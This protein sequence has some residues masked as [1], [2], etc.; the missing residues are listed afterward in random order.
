MVRI[1]SPPPVTDLV[2]GMLEVVQV[3]EHQRHAGA[4][5]LRTPEH[6]VQR[7]EQAAAIEQL[8]QRVDQ[9]QPRALLG[10]AIER[11]VLVQPDT[12][13]A[14]VRPVADRVHA[15][16]HQAAVGQ[17]D[18]AIGQCDLAIA[19][20]RRHHQPVD[21]RRVAHAHL[22]AQGRQDLRHVGPGGHRPERPDLAEHGIGIQHALLRIDEQDA[23]A[24]RT[25]QRRQPRALVVRA[26]QV[27]LL[28]TLAL[29]QRHHAMADG[30]RHAVETRR[31]AAD[32]VAGLHRN[33]DVVTSRRDL[34]A[35]G[36][37]D[38]QVARE[39]I[40]DRR[41]QPDRRG[42]GH[43]GDE[44]AGGAKLV[45]CMAQVQGGQAQFDPCELLAREGHRHHPVRGRIRT[46]Q[47]DRTGVA[48]RQGLVLVPAGTGHRVP[49][50]VEHDQ[51]GHD[52]RIANLVEHLL[53]RHEITFDDGLHQRLVEQPHQF[54]RLHGRLLLQRALH[55]P[56]AAE[57]H[58]HH[59]EQLHQHTRHD[60]LAAQ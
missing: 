40:G 28:L 32:L 47:V 7:L 20:R 11:D 23:A 34:A 59:R 3:D 2:V 6:H 14:A 19:G 58:Q 5:F 45:A 48:R 37:H 33:L 57:Q 46:I 29:A 22:L 50:M 35:G 13:P 49:A 44:H 30:G 60:E 25:E 9:G 21:Q 36:R 39:R 53:H 42:Q 4:G 17:R 38:G 1:W 27:Q 18:L 43:R 52:L 10:L 56:R 24:Q 54:V 55:Q 12:A 31:Q 26:G 15:L 16:R 41:Q 8:G 51:V